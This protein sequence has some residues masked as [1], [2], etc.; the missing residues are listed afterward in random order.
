[1]FRRVI[2]FFIGLWASASPT[3]PLA[4]TVEVPTVGTVRGFLTGAA[5]SALVMAVWVSDA[6]V[7]NRLPL[8][9]SDKLS[10]LAQLPYL[11]QP[12]L[13]PTP[14]A[15]MFVVIRQN[16]AFRTL[17]RGKCWMLVALS[18]WLTA[19]PIQLRRADMMSMQLTFG[20]RISDGGVRIRK[21]LGSACKMNGNM[22]LTF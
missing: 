16:I 7:A 1:M 18:M 9:A 17:D 4:K 6:L 11:P 19:T 22:K 3:S 8:G 14:P 10:C 5:S 21:M 12:L 2:S 20:F 15:C 13:A